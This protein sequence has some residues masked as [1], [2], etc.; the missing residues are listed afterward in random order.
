[1]ADLAYEDVVDVARGHYAPESFAHAVRVANTAAAMAATYGV[2]AEE[3]RLAGLLHDWARDIAGDEL[4]CSAEARGFEVTD[5]DRE[6]PYLLHARMGEALVRETFPSLPGAVARAVAAHTCGAEGMTDLDR[7]VYVADMIEPGRDF[8]GVDDL[9]H[10]AGNVPLVELFRRAY[11]RSVEHLIQ[12]RRH[13]HPD[14]VAPAKS[15][16]SRAVPF[17]RRVEVKPA[18]CPSNRAVPRSGSE[19]GAVRENPATCATEPAMPPE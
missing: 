14:T 3:A 15:T 1:V 17:T 10:A 11:T 19:V 5:L 7:L 6:V 9:R 16:S 4:T 12:T 18:Y 2:D 13:I 8:E